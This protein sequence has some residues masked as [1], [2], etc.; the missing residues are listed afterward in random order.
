MRVSRKEQFQQVLDVPH[1]CGLEWRDTESEAVVGRLL[2][3]QGTVSVR[4]PY[5]Y[6]S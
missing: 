1:A 3:M 2:Q 5:R 6:R 4:R